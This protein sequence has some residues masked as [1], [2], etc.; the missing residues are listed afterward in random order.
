MPSEKKCKAMLLSGSHMGHRCNN[1]I[2]KH[3]KYYC[4]LHMRKKGKKHHVLSS[5]TCKHYMPERSPVTHRK[6][7]K[8]RRSQA[9]KKTAIA[10]CAEA[11]KW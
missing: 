5:R 1:P 6:W 9:N 4:H 8:S 10:W 3:S 2:S 7:G 11:K